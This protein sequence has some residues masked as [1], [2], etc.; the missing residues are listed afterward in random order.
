VDSPATELFLR[1]G[2]DRRLRGGHLWV[3]SNEVDSVRSPLGNFQAGELVRVNSSDG[4][5][6]GSA[7]ME[8]HAL[9]CARL[10]APGEQRDLDGS[11]FQS[12]LQTALEGRSAVFDQPFYRLVYGDS[13]TL[14]GFR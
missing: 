9:I 5:L 8:P 3:Y 12:R 11:L 10:Y 1:K 6:L 4:R 14:P 2:A 7:Y 13:D